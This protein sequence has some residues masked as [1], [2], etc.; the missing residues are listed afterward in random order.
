MVEGSSNSLHPFERITGYCQFS[1]CSR[2]VLMSF[3]PGVF[4]SLLQSNVPAVADPG[5][6]GLVAVLGLQFCSES[7]KSDKESAGTAVSLILVFLIGH[8]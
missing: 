8:Y 7:D 4:D 3:Q 2:G 1:R 5:P 6:G